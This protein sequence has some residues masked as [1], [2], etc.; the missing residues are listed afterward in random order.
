MENKHHGNPNIL[1]TYNS[2]IKLNDLNECFFLTFNQGCLIRKLM[3]VTQLEKLI[4]LDDI[5][6][7]I[8]METKAK[9]K[10]KTKS[11]LDAIL[12]PTQK[13]KE[14]FSV[15]NSSRCSL[16]LVPS[17]QNGYNMYSYHMNKKRKNV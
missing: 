2:S 6:R 12:H 7:V 15:N 5:D 11:K 4:W 1:I 14:D 9:G 13:N 10:P 17:V 8:M 16:Y 3:Q